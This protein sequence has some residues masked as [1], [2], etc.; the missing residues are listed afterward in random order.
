MPEEYEQRW[1][2]LPAYRRR[3]N[4]PLKF[5]TGSAGVNHTCGQSE[6]GALHYW[7]LNQWAQASPDEPF[8]SAS[9]VVLRPV[10]IEMEL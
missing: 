2:I 6:E 10:E 7:G 4:S 9:S 3:S 8:G 1:C 5:T